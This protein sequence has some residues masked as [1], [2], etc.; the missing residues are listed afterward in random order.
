MAAGVGH[1]NPNILVKKKI[2]YTYSFLKKV[3]LE[4]EK[5]SKKQARLGFKNS[6]EIGSFFWG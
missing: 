4:N 1:M 2:S 6:E 3:G 5:I